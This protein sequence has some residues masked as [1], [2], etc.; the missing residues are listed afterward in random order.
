MSV[1]SNPDYPNDVGT[2]GTV[3]RGLGLGT[4]GAGA[5]GGAGALAYKALGKKLGRVRGGGVAGL[6]GLLAAHTVSGVAAS[7]SLNNRNRDSHG[8]FYD[9]LTQALSGDALS[10]LHPGFL[11]RLYGEE[12]P[13]EQTRDGVRDFLNH[14][15]ESGGDRLV[16]GDNRI[17][18]IIRT[19]RG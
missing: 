10:R 16:R 2:L 8:A 17:R 9:L 15:Y 3:M 11:K 5:G 1:L 13:L 6:A 18:E 7:R 19:Q 4:L 14:F 12:G